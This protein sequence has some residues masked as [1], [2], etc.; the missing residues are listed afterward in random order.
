MPAGSDPRLEGFERVPR[1]AVVIGFHRRAAMIAEYA[2][3]NRVNCSGD[4]EFFVRSQ[5][6]GLLRTFAVAALSLLG[7]FA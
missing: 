3:V 5:F 4:Y 2:D 7:H 1:D 6:F